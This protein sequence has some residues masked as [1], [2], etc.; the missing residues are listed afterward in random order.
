M[1]VVAEVMAVFR[2]SVVA[3]AIL[4]FCMIIMV[5]LVVAAFFVSL[6]TAMVFVLMMFRPLETPGLSKLV[7]NIV[8]PGGT[9]DI[10]QAVAYLPMT[11]VI[12]NVVVVIEVHVRAVDHH[13]DAE[14]RVVL[15]LMIIRIVT[16]AVCGGMG[17]RW[18]TAYDRG[19]AV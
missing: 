17:W 14:A 13:I 4:S 9:P 18:V 3:I 16:I 1:V 2:M 10:L 7:R 15:Q 19:V 5:T 6:F 12:T 11:T 8:F